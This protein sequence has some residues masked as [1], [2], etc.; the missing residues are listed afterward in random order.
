VPE[1]NEQ[2]TGI[3]R[4]RVGFR[5]AEEENGSR[6]SQWRKKVP[7]NKDFGGYIGNDALIAK[8]RQRAL[9]GIAD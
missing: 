3:D 1:W 8:M 7:T 9:F 2:R 6:E 4:R 5:D